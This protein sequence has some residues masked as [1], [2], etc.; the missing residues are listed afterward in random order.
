MGDPDSFPRVANIESQ[1][2]LP[3]STNPELEPV[4]ALSSLVVAL[5]LA[6]TKSNLALKEE[7]RAALGARLE[8]LIN[9]IVLPR[10]TAQHEGE[11]LIASLPAES[12]PVVFAHLRRPYS[13]RI[14]WL[15]G[16]LPRFNPFYDPNSLPGW[17]ARELL[18]RWSGLTPLRHDMTTAAATAGVVSDAEQM[19]PPAMIDPAPMKKRW[20][21]LPW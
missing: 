9:S 7:T 3:P 19:Q 5:W 6:E 8:T 1:E 20:R 13:R 12:L 4:V 17:A 11:S 18:I 2:D 14:D 15:G 10:R 21:F 16:D